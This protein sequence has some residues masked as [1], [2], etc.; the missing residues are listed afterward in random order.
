MSENKT[1]HAYVGTYSTVEAAEAD[2]GAIRQLGKTGTLA[3]YDIALVTKNE[4]G[5]IKIKKKETITKTGAEIGLLAGVLVGV[6]V[7]P[8]LLV[9]AAG[10]AVAGGL[11]GHFSR[12]L[13]RKDAQ[14]LG[15]TLLAGQGGIILVGVAN[16]DDEATLALGR[17]DDVQAA[18]FDVETHHLEFDGETDSETVEVVATDGD[19]VVEVTTVSS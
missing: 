3:N 11:V 18:I 16:L 19:E 5:K 10:G 17:A 4:H 12:G 1:L 7:P 6:V 2:Y 8:L 13:S 9:E 14:Q 15:E